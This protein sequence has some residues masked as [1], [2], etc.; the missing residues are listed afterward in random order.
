[1]LT[2]RDGTLEKILMSQY[3]DL[4]EKRVSLLQQQCKKDNRFGRL[5][6]ESAK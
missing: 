6:D 5:D 4:R 1:M 2:N 3:L